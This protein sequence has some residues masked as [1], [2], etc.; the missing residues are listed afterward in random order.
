MPYFVLFYET[1]DN[2]VEKRAPYRSQHLELARAA[3]ARGELLLAGALADPP[4]RAVLIFRTPDK[5]TV[6]AFARRDPYVLNGAIKRWEVRPWTVVIGNDPAEPAPT[7][8]PA[9]R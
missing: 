3:N 6:E 5:A 8:P 2:Y 1:A 4:D 7:P 9:G